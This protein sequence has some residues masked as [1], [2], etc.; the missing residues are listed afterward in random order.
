MNSFNLAIKNNTWIL[1]L[2]AISF[3]LIFPQIGTLLKPLL[4][5]LLMALMFLSCLDLRLPQITQSLADYKNISLSLVIVHLVSPLIVLLLRPLFSE[6][7]FLGLIIASV[8]PAGRS[9]VFLSNIYGGSPVNALVTSSISNAI[10]PIAV[11]LLVFLLAHTSIKINPV[12]IGSTIFYM[13]IIP[14]I[15]GVLFGKSSAGAKLNKF[16]SSF[17]AVIL[18]LIII[19]II[20]PVQS[21]IVSQPSLIISL[22]FLVTSLISINFFLG[23]LL[24]NNPKNNITYA[25]TSSYKNYTLGTLICLT[26]F[27]P[28]VALPSLAYTISN[29]LLLIPLQL[30]LKHDQSQ[31]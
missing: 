3:S 10:S 11:P 16:S 23:K 13:V 30:F 20:S 21:I 25:L 27:S 15:A 7:I 26:L 12:E 19:G 2:L 22:V 5:P 6:E 8:M 14:L 28:V 24:G 18:I 31:K 1:I 4:S 29:N 17:S 9:S